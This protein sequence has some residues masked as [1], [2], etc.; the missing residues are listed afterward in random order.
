MSY[1]QQD[2][3]RRDRKDSGDEIEIEKTKKIFAPAQ[4]KVALAAHVAINKGGVASNKF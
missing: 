3:H 4:S 2:L 1:L